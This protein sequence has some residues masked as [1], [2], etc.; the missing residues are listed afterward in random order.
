MD[1]SSRDA[2]KIYSFWCIFSGLYILIIK[3][4]QIIG[5]GILAS[6]GDLNTADTVKLK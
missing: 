4:P 5:K 2:R 3:Y 6:F 1:D